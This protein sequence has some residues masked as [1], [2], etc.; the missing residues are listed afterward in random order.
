[1]LQSSPGAF[2]YVLTALSL[3]FLFQ[4]FLAIAFILPVVNALTRLRTNYLPRA[5]SL[6]SVLEDGRGV[7]PERTN[8]FTRWFS[9][10]HKQSGKIGP[11]VP[12]L[13]SMIQ[14]I[15]RLEGVRGLFKG[16]IPMCVHM[17][18]TFVF[19][20]S[21]VDFS[22]LTSG[23]LKPS[24]QS[25]PFLDFLLSLITYLVVFPFELLMRRTMTCPDFVN[26]LRP[27]TALRH[28]LSPE[29]VLHPWRLYL[30]P[31]LIPA[32]LFRNVILIRLTLL[33]RHWLVPA[34]DRLKEVAPADPKH[35]VFEGPTSALYQ[36]SVTGMLSFLLFMGVIAC[37][38]TVLDC[39]LV[40]LMVQY[41]RSTT[42]SAPASHNHQAQVGAEPISASEEQLSQEPVLSLRHC[43]HTEDTTSNYFGT[44]QVEPYEGV[45]DCMQKMYREEG[46]ESLFR[47]MLYTVLGFA[48]VVFSS[49]T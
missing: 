15:R 22:Y 20:A 30:I 29:E 45:F 2:F 43:F 5:V 39:V 31:G 14:R 49:E 38:C 7:E 33:V 23:H 44:A 41:D 1:M 21:R 28:V 3:T 24:S 16:A 17:S 46:S 8:I 36:I 34:F 25:H 40:R 13:W 32:V 6:D 35:D 48:L 27:R 37:V 19:L 42:I 11:V 12:G 26:W 4:N 18:L 47:G 9:R 10:V